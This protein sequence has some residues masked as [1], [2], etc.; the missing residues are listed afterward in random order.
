MI[1]APAPVKTPVA[2]EGFRSRV[3]VIDDEPLIRWALATGLS[4]SGYDT[5]AAADTGEALAVARMRPR[6]DVILLDLHQADCSRLLAE[7]RAIAPACRIMVLGT[8]CEGTPASHWHGLE[9]IPK[10]FDLA[11]VVRRVDEASARSR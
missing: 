4:A 10:P 1:S 2:P 7:L 9:M 8:C 5:V 3:L 11:D 6:P